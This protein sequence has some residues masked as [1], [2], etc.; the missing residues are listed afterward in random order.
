MRL[1][2]F[3][4]KKRFDAFRSSIVVEGFL[5]TS[6]LIMVALVLGANIFR[7][8]LNG[9]SN[10]ETYQNEK[11]SLSE[12]EAKNVELLREN[13]FVNSDEYKRLILRESSNLASDNETLFDI[14]AKPIYYQEEKEY[15]DIKLK[16]DFTDWWIKLIR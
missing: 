15:L 1:G 9:K 4:I 8:V 13:E 12:I 7:V 2:L 10:Y 5:F 16:R 6:F 11:E 3:D 14:K